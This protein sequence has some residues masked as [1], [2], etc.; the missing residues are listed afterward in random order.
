M[1]R[2]KHLRILHLGKYFPPVR[3]GI[4][5]FLFDLA[6]AQARAGDIPLVLAHHEK[7][8]KSSIMETSAPLRVY[9]TA[10]VGTL[11]YAP[12]APEYPFT[13]NRI[14]KQ[15]NP[16][17]IHAHLPNTSVFWLLLLARRRPVVVHWHSDVVASSIDRRLAMAYRFYRPFER[18]LLDLAS[19]IIPTSQPYLRSSIALRNFAHKCTVIPLGLDPSRLYSPGEQE[20]RRLR[21]SYPGQSL[22]ASA[23]RFAYYKG[24]NFLIDAAKDLTGTTLVIAG[25][26]KLRPSMAER[27]SNLGLSERVYLPGEIEDKE[28]HTL[29]AACDIFCLPSVERTEAFGLTILEA[30][31]F[32]RPII[33][34]AIEGSGAGWVNEN[35]KT[36]LVVPPGDSS[37][38][39]SAIHSLM[40]SPDRR[41][42]M[43]QNAR[44]RFLSQ[45]HIDR[46][47][48]KVQELYRSILS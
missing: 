14:L 21:S 4:E 25:D 12:I 22:I 36:G 18:R 39:E 15:F 24:F 29:M 5:N 45:F 38:L 3:G 8:F 43:G 11:L 33:S 32:A 37:A 28:L 46:I 7:P 41:I 9:R 42:R 47:A 17:V 2:D 23:G 30:M 40:S 34:T 27:T 35:E 20:L 31:A 1:P 13:L 10:T 48:Q 6:R 44:E 26:G 19:A 16:H